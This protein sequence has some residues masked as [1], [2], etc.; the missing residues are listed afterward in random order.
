MCIRVIY[1]G[2]ATILAR[3]NTQREGGGYGYR[4][5]GREVA[6]H[7]MCSRG[8]ES[9]SLPRCE[10][11]NRIGSLLGTPYNRIVLSA[12]RLWTIYH[13]LLHQAPDKHFRIKDRGSTSTLRARMHTALTRRGNFEAYLIPEKTGKTSTDKKGN[14]GVG[15]AQIDSAGQAT[16]PAPSPST[17][18]RARL[19][20]GL[21]GHLS[22][23]AQG[24][25]RLSPTRLFLHTRGHVG[26]N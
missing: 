11:S 14:M 1:P 9:L 21:S 2:A 6:D 26:R 5:Q 25:R 7:S 12:G 20:I 15:T 3:T 24:G 22:R 8:G 23:Q 18:G 10:E 17:C 13:V 19:A 16:G 4:C